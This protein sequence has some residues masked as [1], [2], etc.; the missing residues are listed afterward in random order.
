MAH[1]K[2]GMCGEL[3]R[4][5]YNHTHPCPWLHPHPH[6]NIYSNHIAEFLNLK[7]EHLRTKLEL[8]YHEE[9]NERK[10]G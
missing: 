10:K 3:E 9:I 7:A 6:R 8:E 2:I 5:M 4:R 1:L